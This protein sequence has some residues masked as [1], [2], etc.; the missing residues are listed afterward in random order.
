MRC[1][2]CM[3]VEKKLDLGCVLLYI[4]I[5][6]TCVEFYPYKIGKIRKVKMK[7]KKMKKVDSLEFYYVTRL[8]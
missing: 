8:T 3:C 5:F 6:I 7:V 1:V 2:P 4:Y